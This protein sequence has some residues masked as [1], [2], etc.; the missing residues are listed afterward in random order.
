M[1][2]TPR[3]LRRRQESTRSPAPRSFQPTTNPGNFPSVTGTLSFPTASRGPAG[4]LTVAHTVGAHPQEPSPPVNRAALNSRAHWFSYC[5][6]HTFRIGSWGGTAKH[7]RIWL[8][9]ARFSSVTVDVWHSHLPRVDVSLACSLANRVGSQAWISA[10]LIFICVSPNSSEAEH[11][12]PYPGVTLLRSCGV[13]SSFTHL[14]TRSPIFSPS[15]R[16]F[17]VY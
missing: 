11:P 3:S 10:H 8:G 5:W 6:W 12:F 15:M 1:T 2:L 17:F 16:T 7:R 4:G 9:T 14:P 13:A